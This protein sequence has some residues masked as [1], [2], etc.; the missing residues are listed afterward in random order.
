MEI[1]DTAVRVI[2]PLVLLTLV[3]MVWPILRSW[4]D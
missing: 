1:L 3:V 4:H 2:G